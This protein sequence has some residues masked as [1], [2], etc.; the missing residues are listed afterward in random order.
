V[1]KLL[2]SERLNREVDPAKAEPS[3]AVLISIGRALSACQPVSRHL[4]RERVWTKNPGDHHDTL[5]EIATLDLEQLVH[6]VSFVSRE[7]E[8]ARQDLFTNPAPAV[9][10]GVN[11]RVARRATL[12][13]EMDANPCGNSFGADRH[14]RDF[15]FALL[16][17]PNI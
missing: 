11:N 2:E 9:A 1:R 3:V 7:Q 5:F 8:A 16:A 12:L 15:A 10:A 17:P 4:I 13:M 6:P 14:E